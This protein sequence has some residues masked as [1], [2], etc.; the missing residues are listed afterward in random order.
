MCENPL[1]EIYEICTSDGEIHAISVMLEA[2]K[3]HVDKSHENP[4]SEENI[5]E[6]QR[7][8]VRCVKYVLER[9]DNYET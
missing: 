9:V 5:I 4:S 3:R 2:L 6:G 1:I 8:M 7:A